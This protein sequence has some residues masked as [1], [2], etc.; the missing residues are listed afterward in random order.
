MKS[1]GI[2]RG[3][4]DLGRIVVPKEVRTN[5]N[6]NQYD[7][8]EIFTDSDTVILRKYNKGCLI[9]GEMDNLNT[10]DGVT[11]CKKCLSKFKGEK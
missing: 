4:D 3:L 8:I 11:L 2:T 5:L 7:M 1:T 10:V 6:W 9:C